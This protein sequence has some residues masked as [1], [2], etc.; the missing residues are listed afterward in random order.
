VIG[1]IVGDFFFK[2]GQ[3]GNGILIEIYRTRLQS[4]RLFAAVILSSLLG[5]GVFW[6]FSF[7]ARQV[8]GRWH[9]SARGDSG[10]G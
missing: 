5:L 4:E 1:A 2:Q 10:W 7:A 3:P 6:A 8:V 9:E